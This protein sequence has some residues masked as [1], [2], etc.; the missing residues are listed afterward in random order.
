MYKDLEYCLDV[1]E[2]SAHPHP[3]AFVPNMCKVFYT[4]LAPTGTCSNQ[5]TLPVNNT[6]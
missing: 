4:V 5:G 6:L 3:A 2:T 1:H